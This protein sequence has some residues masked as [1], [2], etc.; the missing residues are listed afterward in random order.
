MLTIE[1]IKSIPPNSKDIPHNPCIKA[2]VLDIG[3]LEPA[4]GR[5]KAKF[6]CILGDETG[7]ISCTVY[8]ENEKPKFVKD[9]G[10]ILM[11]IM[12][13]Q[14]YIAVTELLFVKDTPYPRKLKK[15]PRSFQQNQAWTYLWCY[16]HPS[17][18]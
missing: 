13:K 17:K 18:P 16:I 4:Q 5:A 2:T 1:K 9:M 7:S 15:M 14:S 10:V 11:N 6:F 12:I 3:E 8:K